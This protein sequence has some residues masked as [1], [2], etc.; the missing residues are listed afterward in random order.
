MTRDSF[1][2]AGCDILNF[3][4]DGKPNFGEMGF[5]VI[6]TFC[7]WHNQQPIPGGL[8][9]QSRWVCLSFEIKHVT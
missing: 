4:L 1:I 8:G 2:Q 3:L 9:Q 6:C 7:T 5:F